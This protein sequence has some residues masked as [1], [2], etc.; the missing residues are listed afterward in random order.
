MEK[1]WLLPVSLSSL[2]FFLPFLVW[3]QN[4]LGVEYMAV[5][6]PTIP[7]TGVDIV[8]EAK[9][10]TPSFYAGRAEPVS[11]SNIKLTAILRNKTSSNAKELGYR[12]EVAGQSQS[13]QP[14]IGQQTVE[15]TADYITQLPVSVQIFSAS[16]TAIAGAKESVNLSTPQLMFYEVN[17]LRGINKVAINKEVILSGDETTITAMPYFID[18]NSVGSKKIDTTWTVDGKKVPEYANQWQ[19]NL[20]RSGS[21]NS[22]VIGFD[23]AD[24]QKVSQQVSG[25]FIFKI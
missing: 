10:F 23:F 14:I 11:G 22:T 8:V 15:V 24:K 3:A 25:S 18:K 1:N 16:G 21:K 13:A 6:K 17:L 12:W 5:S 20:Q 19:I 4:P 9:T 7:Q 2:I